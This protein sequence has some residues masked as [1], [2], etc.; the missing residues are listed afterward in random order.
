MLEIVFHIQLFLCKNLIIVFPV[1]ASL[2]L[3]NLIKNNSR[4]DW[5]QL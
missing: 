5:D 3:L 1:F 4:C 2:V